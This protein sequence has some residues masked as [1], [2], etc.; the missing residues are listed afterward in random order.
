MLLS[1]KTVTV[2]W[3]LQ[4][5]QTSLDMRSRQGQRD[6]LVQGKMQQQSLQLQKGRKNLR[7]SLSPKQL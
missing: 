5:H 7:L 2:P 6:M 4:G 1:K 3:S